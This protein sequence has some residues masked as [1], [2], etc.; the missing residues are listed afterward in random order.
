MFKNNGLLQGY[1]KACDHA[2]LEFSQKTSNTFTKLP[3]L[4]TLKHCQTDKQCSFGVMI[5][6]VPFIMPNY[7]TESELLRV[8]SSG[9][10]M[11]MPISDDQW[12]IEDI[13]DTKQEGPLANPIR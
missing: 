5:W 2:G 12:Q 10:K 9:R 4:K 11:L 3:K 8:V 6:A 1:S 7:R 13:M